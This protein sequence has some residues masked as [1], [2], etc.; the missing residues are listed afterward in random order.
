MEAASADDL[1]CQLADL[2]LGLASLPPSRVNGV[3]N[4]LESMKRQA[5]ALSRRLPVFPTLRVTADGIEAQGAFAEAQAKV[6][7][8]QPRMRAPVQ[9]G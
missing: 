9:C 5:R 2:G 1:A 3:R 7:A 8:R 4:M 6:R